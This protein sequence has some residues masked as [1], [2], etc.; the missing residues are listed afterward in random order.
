MVRREGE[1]RVG[2][3]R[4]FWA[5]GL[6]EVQVCR[7][8]FGVLATP[9]PRKKGREAGQRGSEAPPLALPSPHGRC[10][11]NRPLIQFCLHHQDGTFNQI[12]N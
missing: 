11:D 12:L 9:A 2:G 10:R 8:K 5:S 3:R 7:E 1:R 4:R 6:G